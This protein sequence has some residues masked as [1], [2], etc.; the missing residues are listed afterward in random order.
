[1]DPIT[2]AARRFGERVCAFLRS[3]RA[4]TLRIFAT[5]EDQGSVV[6][7]LRLI[8][9]A[10]DNRRPFFLYEEPFTDEQT[11]FDGLA[12][13]VADDYAR[14]GMPMPRFPREG[15]AIIRASAIIARVAEQFGDGMLVGLLPREA[16]PEGF[17][18][19]WTGLA[20]PVGVKLAVIGAEGCDMEA[21][22]ALNP[23]E[24]ARFIK[25]ASAEG[26]SSKR[27]V[28]TTSAITL[29]LGPALEVSKSPEILIA[30]AGV[31]LAAGNREAACKGFMGAAQLAE[32][33]GDASGA[34][35]AW[36]AVEALAMLDGLEELAALAREKAGDVAS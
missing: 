36:R 31:E 7:T 23:G 24:V 19:A 28:L 8:E 34:A 11:Y 9:H 25:A 35:R 27:A 18:R 13:K 21:R 5:P 6:Q 2:M 15:D 26:A 14:L 4:R 32:Q 3:K 17:A 12:M 22:F 1:M 20:L 30:V 29:D 16:P 10:P 33:V